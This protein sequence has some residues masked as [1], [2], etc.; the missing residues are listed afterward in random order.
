MPQ[1]VI[2]D[3]SPRLKKAAA[4]VTDA[5]DAYRLRVKALKKLVVQAVDE[6]MSQRQIAA[7]AGY[8]S[9]GRITQILA[10]GE[11]D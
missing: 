11:D 10:E 9:A 6:G 3:L 1:T 4:E 8:K 7:A 2:E 5:R